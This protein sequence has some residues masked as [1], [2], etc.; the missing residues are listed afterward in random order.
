MSRPAPFEVTVNVRNHWFKRLRVKAGLS[1]HELADL[2]G[3]AV[4]W[5]VAFEGFKADHTTTRASFEAACKVAQCLGVTV[6]D[7]FPPER[8]MIKASTSASTL[9]GDDVARMISVANRAALPE[10]ALGQEDVMDQ[11]DLSR[12]VDSALDTITPREAEVLRRRFGIG[13]DEEALLEIAKHFNVTQER[14]RQIEDKALRK[15]RHPSRAKM[16]AQWGKP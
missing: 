6:D 14:I 10:P 5:I 7:L 8:S 2:A 4:R 9:T 12:E 16:L 11:I 15:L 3:V 1:Q 13:C